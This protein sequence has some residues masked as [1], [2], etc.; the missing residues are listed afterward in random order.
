MCVLWARSC[1]RRAGHIVVHIICL[2]LLLPVI[3]ILLTQDG[4]KRQPRDE[5]STRAWR[6]YSTLIERLTCSHIGLSAATR[7]LLQARRDPFG[8]P[9]PKNES[10]IFQLSLPARLMLGKAMQPSSRDSFPTRVL[11]HSGPMNRPLGRRNASKLNTIFR[12]GILHI[13]S[14]QPRRLCSSQL[15]SLCSFSGC[16]ALEIQRYTEAPARLIHRSHL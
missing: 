14:H 4:F 12:F 13:R 8:P 3:F 1:P 9:G 7:L 2:V 6:L 16:K 11:R 15:R 5:R 10:C